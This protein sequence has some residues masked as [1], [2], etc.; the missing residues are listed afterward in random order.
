MIAFDCMGVDLFGAGDPQTL[1][2]PFLIDIGLPF[3]KVAVLAA[4]M[5]AFQPAAQPIRGPPPDLQ[6]SSAAFF[7]ATTRLLI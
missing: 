4:H 7:V 2:A 1:K 5:G 6:K 3:P